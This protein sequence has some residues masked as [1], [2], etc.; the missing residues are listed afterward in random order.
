M[1]TIKR[2]RAPSINHT[3]A[4]NTNALLISRAVE[5][6][7]AVLCLSRSTKLLEIS[8]VPNRGIKC[9]AEFLENLVVCWLIER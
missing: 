3:L 2:F 1:E 4:L 9:N 5:Q 7:Y 6:I 8:V